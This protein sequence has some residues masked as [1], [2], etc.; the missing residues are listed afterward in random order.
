MPEKYCFGVHHLALLGE[1]RTSLEAAGYICH[2]ETEVV[3]MYTLYILVATPAPR[4]NR[5]ERG[6]EL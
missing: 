5:K 1:T 2:V 6:C 3:G 4:P